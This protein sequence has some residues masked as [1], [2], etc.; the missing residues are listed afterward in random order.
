MKILLN[1]YIY[2]FSFILNHVC[3]MKFDESILAGEQN[4]A[5]NMYLESWNLLESSC[6]R[7]VCSLM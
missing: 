1:L 6:G 4:I 3:E 5:C 2:I 7:Y